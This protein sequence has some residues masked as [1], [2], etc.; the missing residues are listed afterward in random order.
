MLVFVIAGL[1]DSFTDACRDICLDLLRR[2]GRNPVA[3]EIGLGSDLPHLELDSLGSLASQVLSAEADIVVGVSRRGD[4]AFTEALVSSGRLYLVALDDPRWA[5]LSLYRQGGGTDL[6]GAIRNTGLACA[7]LIELLLAANARP[8]LFESAA[9]DKAGFARQVIE[10]LGLPDGE[11]DVEA[12]SSLA[13]EK[14]PSA[15]RGEISAELR[16]SLNDT[17][18][19]AVQGAL[20]GFWPAFQ[21]RP[22]GP[23]IA[24]R[25]L[26]YSAET[27]APFTSPTIDA[28][29]RARCVSFGPYVSLPPGNWTLRLVM[30]FSPE[31]AGTPFTLD[32]TRAGRRATEELGRITFDAIV[33]RYIAQIT[34]NHSEP[35]RA[36][37]FRLFIDKPT[38]EGRISI[39]FAELKRLEG[40]A[41]DPSTSEVEWRSD[42]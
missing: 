28:T 6:P 37:E 32:V 3:M 12:A 20:A 34:F 35:S 41:G 11:A 1:H 36:L 8:I 22:L 13:A 2:A 26:F 29:G 24:T 4:R 23:I 21:G 31:L 39:G 38:F 30:A 19:L 10:V 16:S 7:C 17:E 33:G 18:A 9:A 40:P 25:P 14:L 15:A 27:V 5:A 42:E